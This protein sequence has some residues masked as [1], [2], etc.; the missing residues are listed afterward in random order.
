MCPRTGYF[1]ISKVAHPQMFESFSG[2]MEGQQFERSYPHSTIELILKLLSTAIQFTLKIYTMPLTHCR[3]FKFKTK[4]T[5]TVCLEAIAHYFSLKQLPPYM[6][7]DSTG[8]D[9]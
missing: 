9:N 3:Y 4:E 5:K 1:H 7:R 2:N 6:S 8:R